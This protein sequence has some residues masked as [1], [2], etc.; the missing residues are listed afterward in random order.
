MRNRHKIKKTFNY[1]KN[2]KLYREKRFYSAVSE[3][4]ILCPEKSYK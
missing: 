3:N 4:R 2:E 1:Q